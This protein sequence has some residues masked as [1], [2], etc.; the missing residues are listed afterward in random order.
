MNDLDIAKKVQIEIVKKITGVAS[1]TQ[2]VA[3]QTSYE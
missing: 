3:I 2:K 1:Q